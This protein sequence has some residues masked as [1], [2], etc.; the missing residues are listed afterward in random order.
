MA[1]QRG[2]GGGLVINGS[3]TPAAPVTP[4]RSATSPSTPVGGHAV[5]AILAAWTSRP[6]RPRCWPPP[7]TT[8]GQVPTI[9]SPARELIRAAAGDPAA[10]AATATVV[11]HLATGLAN[12]V[13]LLNPDRIVLGGL[14]ADLLT[15]HKTR[16]QRRLAQRSFLDQAAAV[17]LHPEQ[18]ASSALLGAAELVMQPLLDDPQQLGSTP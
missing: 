10:S 12:L 5:V 4:S 17:A 18:L 15:Q 13:N 16:L 9:W 11:D 8:S 3:S 1:G 7:A 14:L 2:I 6:T